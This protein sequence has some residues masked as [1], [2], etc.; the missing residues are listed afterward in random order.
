MI[1]VMARLATRR[2]V[3]ATRAPSGV[4]RP[5]L[6]LA[7]GAFGELLCVAILFGGTPR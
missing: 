7:M 5:A 1:V 3:P 2:P 4:G 6:V